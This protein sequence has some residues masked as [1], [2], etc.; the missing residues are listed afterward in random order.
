MLKSIRFIFFSLFILLQHVSSGNIAYKSEKPIKFS[1]YI[2]NIYDINYDESSYSVIFY[3]WYNSID[4]K[5]NLNDIDVLNALD[6]EILYEELDSFQSKGHTY[7]SDIRKY[8]CKISNE[9]N[10]INFPFDQNTLNL[11]IELEGHISGEY[12]ISLDSVNSKIKPDFIK[13]WHVT[14]TSFK[15]LKNCW[16]SNFG[17]FD[18][19]DDSKPSEYMDL[20][21]DKLPCYDNIQLDINVGRNSW[22]IYLKMFAVLFL[23]LIIATSSIFLPNKHSEEKISIIVGSLFTTIGNKYISDSNLPLID[24]WGLS[25]QLH[26]LTILSILLLTI[27]AI[28]EQRKVLKDSLKKELILFAIINITY[29]SIVTIVTVSYLN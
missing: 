3:F 11:S 21:K 28:Y 14:N 10:I 6:K 8:K 25:D 9:L 16:N 29:F 27:Y 17:D 18:E 22:G 23:A 12:K 5:Y 13:N 4:H 15:L 24:S 2:D 26:F 20:Q 7:Y 1:V 19:N